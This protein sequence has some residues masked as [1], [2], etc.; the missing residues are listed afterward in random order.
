M[1]KPPIDVERV[2]REVLA[3]LGAVGESRAQECH[4]TGDLVVNARVVTMAEVAG[5]L[6]SAR[7]LVVPRKAVV[8]PAMPEA[9]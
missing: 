2:V 1:S 7:R 8:T 6:E 4:N 3:E 9:T 5:R